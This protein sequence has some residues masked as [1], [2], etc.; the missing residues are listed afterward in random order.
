MPAIVQPRGDPI[1]AAAI[2]PEPPPL[3]RHEKTSGGNMTRPHAA[4]DF[5][6]IRARME[7]L[8][9]ER[10]QAMRGNLEEA[11][12]RRPVRRGPIDEQALQRAAVRGRFPA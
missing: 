2:V 7:E 6:A 8:Q 11:L 10:A 3:D 1:R 12:E 4:D 9:R 5:A